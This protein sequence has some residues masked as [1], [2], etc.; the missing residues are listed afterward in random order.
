MDAA[1]EKAASRM[2]ASAGKRGSFR[3]P[4]RIRAA[5]ARSGARFAGPMKAKALKDERAVR[6]L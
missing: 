6:A 5:N 2:P 4:K 1:A 3:R